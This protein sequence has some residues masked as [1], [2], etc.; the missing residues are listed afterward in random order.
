MPEMNVAYLWPTPIVQ[1]KN[2]DHEKIK[3]AVVRYAYDSER[4][5]KTPIESGVTPQKKGNLYES[6]FDFLRAE[7]PGQPGSVKLIMSSS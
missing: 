4:R 2:P 7:I 3:E 6:R 5:A 1:V